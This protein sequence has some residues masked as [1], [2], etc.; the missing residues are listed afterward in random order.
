MSQQPISTL[1][2]VSFGQDWRKSYQA[3]K[4]KSDDINTSYGTVGFNAM[5]L[6][7]G[8]VTMTISSSDA[9]DLATT[10]SGA[11]LFKVTGLDVT[12]NVRTIEGEL[13]GQNAV[14]LGVDLQRVLSIE[15]TSAGAS[16]VNEGALYV[17]EGAVVAGL[18]A[19]IYKSVEIGRNACWDG[20]TT[21]P[22][23]IKAYVTRLNLSTTETSEP[24]TLQVWSQSNYLSQPKQ[25]IYECSFEQSVDMRFDNLVI[26]QKTDV[27][28]E[29]K[30]VSATGVTVDA[31]LEYIKSAEPG[32]Q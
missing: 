7:S 21:V 19:T 24:L 11:R 27:W 1:E 25:L 31:F 13:D 10:G 9:N 20:W 15:V 28:I 14:T 32:Q 18:P 23:Q 8:T 16:G 6:P 30:T 26:R 5:T 22:N 17:G 4:M 3:L 2:Q 29:V 12:W